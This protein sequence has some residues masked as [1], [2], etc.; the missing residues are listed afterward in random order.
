[1]NKDQQQFFKKFGAKVRKCRLEK[2][3]NLEDMQKFDFSAAHF[4]KVESGSK[5]VNFFTVLRIAKAFGLKLKDLVS[6]LD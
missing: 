5:A 4:Q 3:L 1:M 2:G 6:G